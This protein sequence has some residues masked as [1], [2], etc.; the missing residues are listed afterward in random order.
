MA[1]FHED[2][3]EG[4]TLAIACP[5]LDHGQETYLSKLTAL[6][7]E[8]AIQSIRVMIMQVPCCGGLLRLAMKAAE[9][10][11]RPVPVLC[12]VVGINGSVLEHRKVEVARD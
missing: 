7:D 5:K 3:L 4:R 12:T 6:I 8:A 11:R 10:A 1:D 2:C 9:Q